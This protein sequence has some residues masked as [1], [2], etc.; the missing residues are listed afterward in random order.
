MIV[1]EDDVAWPFRPQL[2][3]PEVTS[4]LNKG[5]EQTQSSH[6]LLSTGF[7]PRDCCFL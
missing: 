5:H 3:D 1:L 7:D 6:M 4:F 2:I